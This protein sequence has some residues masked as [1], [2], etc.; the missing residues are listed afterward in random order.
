M[1]WPLKTRNDCVL[2]L[3]VLCCEQKEFNETFIGD[4]YDFLNMR[5]SVLN[6]AVTKEGANHVVS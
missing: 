2:I 3:A 4:E 5:I 6:R 1:L